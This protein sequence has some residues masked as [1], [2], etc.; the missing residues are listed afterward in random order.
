MKYLTQDEVYHKAHQAHIYADEINLFVA[1]NRE[2]MQKRKRTVDELH[3][4]LEGL[5]K[6]LKRN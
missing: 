6:R 1:E 2:L 3:R 4:L 5:D